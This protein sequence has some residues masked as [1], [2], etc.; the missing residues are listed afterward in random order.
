[1]T[2]NNK[3]YRVWI[4]GC[5]DFTHHGHSGAILQARQTVSSYNQNKLICGIHNDEA[6]RLNKG[7]L[8]VMHENERYKHIESIRWV[9]QIVKDAPY[10]T[11][12][13]WMDRY[14][15]RY[16]VHGDDITLDANGEDCY[17]LMKKMDRFMEV[18]RTPVV[19]TTEIIHRILN[20]ETVD[21]INDKLTLEELQKYSTGENGVDKHC[22]VIDGKKNELLVDGIKDIK[23]KSQWVVLTGDFDLFHPGDIEQLENIS[24]RHPRGV[25]IAHITHENGGTIMSLKERVLS[26]LSCRYIDGVVIGGSPAAEWGLT[27][28]LGDPHV[29]SNG[30]FEYLTAHVIQ[31]RINAQR[32][33]YEARNA[34]KRAPTT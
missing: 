4:D 22:F 25:V 21:D 16:V 23:D 15:C 26:V 7:C 18:K 31:D 14:E 30:E 9:S 29:T 1:M 2:L 12:P 6:I 8:P 3:K 19:S 33:R 5:F 28:K 13:E 17:A 10:V 34:K 32:D 20:G 24:K 27:Y 11:D